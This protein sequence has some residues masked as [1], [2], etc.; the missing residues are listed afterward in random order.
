MCPSL[1]HDE[2]LVDVGVAPER[3]EGDELG[4]GDA[5]RLPQVIL[6]V[7]RHGRAERALAAAVPDGEIIW[8]EI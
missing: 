8:R 5:V 6:H 1:W 2:E 3:V 7:D 4:V